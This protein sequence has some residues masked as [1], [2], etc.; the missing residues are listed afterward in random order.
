MT[1]PSTTPMDRTVNRETPWPALDRART[2]AA[3]LF[4]RNNGLW[5]DA[6]SQPERLRLEIDGLVGRPCSF[7]L[8]E[9]RSRFE[10]RRVTAVLECAGNGRGALEP[11]TEGLQWSNGAVGCAEYGGVR[12]G[13]LLAAAEVLPEARHL[14]HHSPDRTP[15]GEV[16]L[17]RGIPIWKAMAPETLVAYEMNGEPLSFEHGGPLRI[18]A[19]GFPGAAWQKWLTRIEVREREHDGA[20]MTGLDYRLP[21]TPLG[22]ADPI[23]PAT[24]RVIEDMPVKSIIT[25]PAGGSVVPLGESIEVRGW[26]WSGAVPVASVE[27]LLDDDGSVEASME[28]TEGPWAWRRFRA[29]WTPGRAGSHVIAARASDVD[30]RRQPLDQAWNP[31]GYCNNGCHRVDVSVE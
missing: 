24:F 20:K 3:D 30:G 23:D 25:H 31:R 21:E 17:S 10:M 9:L 1:A 29:P 7:T 26:A 19:P 11:P 6:A 18:V 5:P 15:T 16:A 13:E 4:V 14:G 22:P 12:L 27:V 28:A 2:A 8:D